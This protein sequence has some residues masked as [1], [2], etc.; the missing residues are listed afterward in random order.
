MLCLAMPVLSLVF[1][2]VLP[3]LPSIAQVICSYF[4]DPRGGFLSY[5]GRS[6]PLAFR[7][8]GMLAVEGIRQVGQ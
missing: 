1:V 2:V 8:P 4:I 7:F 5:D 6:K 3:I